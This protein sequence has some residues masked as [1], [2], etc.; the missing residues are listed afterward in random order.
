MSEPHSP[1]N[2]RHLN[3]IRQELVRDGFENRRVLWLSLNQAYQFLQGKKSKT[4]VVAIIDSGFDTLQQD[5]KV[6][7]G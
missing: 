2:C 1:S 3:L 6:C 7:Y 4:V 5:L